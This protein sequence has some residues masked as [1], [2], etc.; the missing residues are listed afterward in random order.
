MNLKDMLSSPDFQLS[1]K[2]EVELYL[3]AQ[4]LGISK[5]EIELGKWD[6][7]FG[8]TKEKIYS[9]FSERFNFKYHH[10]NFYHIDD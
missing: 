10:D 6:L 8:N 3:L 2:I 1:T 7:E 9:H 5:K 4:D